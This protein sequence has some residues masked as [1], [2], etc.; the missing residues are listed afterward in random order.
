MTAKAHVLELIQKL[1]DEASYEQIAR[2]VELVAGIR[3]AQEQ[4]A[5]GEGFSAEEILKE[6]P[7]WI[8]KS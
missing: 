1:P 5:R 4:I 2:E 7:S 6:M 8:T 3:E